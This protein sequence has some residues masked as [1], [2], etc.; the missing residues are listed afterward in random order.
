MKK[1][2]DYINR[3]TKERRAAFFLAVGTT[4]GYLR[5]ACSV[6]H[7]LGADLCI[8]IERESARA[9]MCEDLRPDCDWAFIRSG[10]V[11]AALTESILQ[12]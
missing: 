3:L 5:K 4:E 12:D 11:V 9:V 1:L 2:R 8:L 6:G 10:D 7:L